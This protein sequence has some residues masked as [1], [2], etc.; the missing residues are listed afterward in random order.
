MSSGPTH[1]P[2][3]MHR[4]AA[5]RG[6]VAALADDRAEHHVGMAADIFGAGLDRQVDA[7]VERAE[8]ERASPRCCPSAPAAPL[9]CAAAA[10]AGTS[11]ISNDSEPGDSTNTARVFGRI[12][13]AIPPPISGS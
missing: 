13:A 3:V 9:A 5:A 11:W 2:S 6:H 1:R 8:V 4:V 7:L 10:I 12:S